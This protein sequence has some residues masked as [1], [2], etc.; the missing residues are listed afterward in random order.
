MHALIVSSGIGPNSIPSA[1]LPVRGR[2]VIDLAISDILNQKEVSKIM[3][4]TK[5]ELLSIHQKHFLNSFPDTLIELTTDLNYVSNIHEDLLIC[6]GNVHTSLKMQDF[7]RAFKQFKK[8]TT[9]SFKTED[10]D[11]LIPYFIIPQ[12]EANL[13]LSYSTKTDVFTLTSFH[14]WLEAKN[15]PSYVFKSGTGFCVSL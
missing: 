7:I 2:A 1:L 3:I 8:I 15:I 11:V 6:D 4:Y 13:L 12:S 5:P 9:P 10:K 14:A